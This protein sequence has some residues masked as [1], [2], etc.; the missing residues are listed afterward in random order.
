[1]DWKTQTIIYAMYIW[2]VLE[3]QTISY[4]VLQDVFEEFKN[5]E[6]AFHQTFNCPANGSQ[7]NCNANLACDH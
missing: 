2:I 4:L 1:M 3:V 5:P 6:R 7:P